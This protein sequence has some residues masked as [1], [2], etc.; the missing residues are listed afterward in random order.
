M[1]VTFEQTK[2]IIE[3]LLELTSYERTIETLY[4]N[5]VRIYDVDSCSEWNAQ[6]QSEAN[7]LKAYNRY[8]VEDDSSE[9]A[10]VFSDN[11]SVFLVSRSL[12]ELHE[13]MRGEGILFTVIEEDDLKLI[14]L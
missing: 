9:L 4:L 11:V 10:I 3:I 6:D 8:N 13:Y 2:E 12:W 5:G 7:L 1:K 14:L